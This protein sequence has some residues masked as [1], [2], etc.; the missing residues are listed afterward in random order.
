M[1]TSYAGEAK[2]RKREITDEGYREEVN[3]DTDLSDDDGDGGND[4]NDKYNLANEDPPDHPAF[5]S[6][7]EKVMTDGTGLIVKFEQM[8]RLHASK[9]EALR[10]M[11]ANAKALCE[12]PKP[13][14]PTFAVVGVCASGKFGNNMPTMPWLFY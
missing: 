11:H 5:S 8:S 1:A 2:K 14:P 3:S 13:T 9:S 10:H 6:D 12:R 4:T 7:L